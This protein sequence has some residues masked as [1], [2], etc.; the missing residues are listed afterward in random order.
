MKKTTKTSIFRFA[1]IGITVLVI[2]L[3]GIF[4]SNF[5]D[6]GKALQQINLVWL[7]GA[8]IC[9]VA[10]WLTDGWL[11]QY[12]TNNMTDGKLSYQKSL[13]I[14]I[15]GLYYCALTP[16]SSG[17]QPFQILYMK[18]EKIPVGASTCVVL[19]K[20][21]AF[22]GTVLVFYVLSRFVLGGAYVHSNAA[23]Y[24]LSITGCV[25]YI[26]ALALFILTIVNENWVLRVGNAI[27]GFLHRVKILKTEETVEKARGSFTKTIEDYNGSA[28]YLKNNIGKM[29][30]SVLI[31]IVNIGFL[32]AITYFIYRAFGLKEYSFIYVMALQAF[33][34]T[35]VSYFPLPG[36][37]G[38]S[39]GGFYAIF[40]AFFPKDI[41][42][43]AL[44]IWRIMTYYIMLAI[45]SL[46]VVLD[47][48]L[49]L[50]RNKNNP[51]AGGYR[52]GG[53]ETK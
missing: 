25:L 5:K 16:S 51:D 1:Y 22:A 38:A 30:L 29:V 36:A 2:V 15:I 27:I 45:G 53:P 48:F 34:Y 24:W 52:V 10:Y 50:R 13:K 17:G 18:K 37:A 14:G 23:V 12:I 26:V 39:E 28:K 49:T 20:F 8:V 19:I 4:D 40:S 35:A 46:V 33:L 7:L 47:E 41:V 42:F 43:M 9:M 31:S 6:M 11:L 3:I 44:L 21:V 32:F